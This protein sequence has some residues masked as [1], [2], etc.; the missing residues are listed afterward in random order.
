MEVFFGGFAAVAC[1]AGDLSIAGHGS[2][3]TP[4]RL[5]VA[6]CV[7]RVMMI[8]TLMVGVHVLVVV[9]FVF[10]RFVGP[11]ARIFAALFIRMLG[12]LTMHAAGLKTL[13]LA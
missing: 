1:R 6:A 10:V 7:A 13:V 4:E 5:I 9:V 11:I 12:V 3:M 8:V 2:V